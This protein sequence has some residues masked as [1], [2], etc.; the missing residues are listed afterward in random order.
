MAM[1][2]RARGRKRRRS[3]SDPGVRRC[4][5]VFAVTAAAAGLAGWATPISIPTRRSTGCGRCTPA[6]GYYSKPPLV[7]WL[8]AAT[9]RS[10][11]RTSSPS[12][13]RRRCCISA[14][15]SSSTPSAGGST[16]R[17][18]P[19]WSAIVYATL[20]GVSVSAAHHLDRCAAAV[21]L[22]GGAL[23]A[24]SGRASRAASAGGRGRRR[25]RFRPARQIRDGLLADF[26]A[27][28]P[29]WSSATSGGICGASRRGRRSRC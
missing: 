24:S 21:L 22:G 28:V 1:Q 10:S 3:K 6:F 7:A 15:A 12:A 27:A 14:P 9:P 5:L 11:A 4:G 16:M 18:S 23:R 8:I 13:W 19:C 17:A 25:R 29:R 20:P 2:A 26:G